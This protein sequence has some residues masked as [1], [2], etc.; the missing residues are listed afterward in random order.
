[1]I[2]WRGTS[3]YQRFCA[4]SFDLDLLFSVYWYVVIWKESLISDC[5]NSHKYPKTDQF[6]L[7]F[8]ATII[9]WTSVY[10]S[11]VDMFIIRVFLADFWIRLQDGYSYAILEMLTILQHMVGLLDFVWVCCV[12][13]VFLLLCFHHCLL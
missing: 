7:H 13:Y 6:I 8:M 12:K 2:R 3:Y 10:Q 1:M 4:F 11:I 9:H 5:Q